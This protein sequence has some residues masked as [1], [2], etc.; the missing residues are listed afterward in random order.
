M[1]RHAQR[2]LRIDL[3]KGLAL[4]MVFIDHVETLV[5][6]SLL[7]RWTLQ[8]L[9]PSDAAELFVILSGLVVGRSYA[10][11]LERSSLLAT[12]RH[13]WWRVAQIYAGYVLA[14]LIVVVLVKLAPLDAF[15]RASF[16]PLRIAP[17]FDSAA[18]LLSLRLVPFGFH[19]FPL[20]I[21]FVS[22]APIAVW[23]LKRSP[24]AALLPA[25]A[26]YLAV[27]ILK[28]GPSAEWFANPRIW[29][30]NPFAWQLAFVLGLAG[31]VVWSRADAGEQS[32]SATREQLAPS[33]SLWAR[34]MLVSSI[35]VLILGWL[36]KRSSP[37]WTLAIPIE[38]SPETL[39]NLCDKPSLGI[40]R[41]L[42]GVAVI[43]CALSLLPRNAQ[44]LNS[45]IVRP[46][47]RC[48][49]HSLLV[50]A[51]S[52]V[53]T[54]ASVIV[55]YRQATDWLLVAFLEVDALAVLCLAAWLAGR[56]RPGS[57]ATSLDTG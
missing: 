31:G 49:Q 28:E 25:A 39:A 40:L 19:F 55:L 12:Q 30:F 38:L 33:N 52:L 32:A 24:L 1:N 9:G 13:A 27:Q 56:W 14:G 8:S 36:M 15:G 54:Y 34:L 26:M 17:L 47:I 23:L 6:V 16:A 7:S 48:G 10:R 5:G 43:C 21:V 4:C 20:Y 11:R 37:E 53:L 42:H 46:I 22:L 44:F 45:A 18:R 2:D 41:L 35:A 29:I 51:L 57:R 3:L 50:Y